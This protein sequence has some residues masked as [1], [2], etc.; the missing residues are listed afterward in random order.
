LSDKE[1]DA[2]V[3]EYEQQFKIPATDVLKHGCDKLIASI[4]RNYP[5]L[6]KKAMQV[7]VE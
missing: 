3:V 5:Q 4:V 7:T 2:V 6:S 1:I